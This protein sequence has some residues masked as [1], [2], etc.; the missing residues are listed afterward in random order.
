MIGSNY[1]ALSGI[2]IKVLWIGGYGRCLHM[3]V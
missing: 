2:I 3:V 1:R